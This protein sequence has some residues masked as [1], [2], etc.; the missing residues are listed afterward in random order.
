MPSLCIITLQIPYC[1]LRSE[2]LEART[3]IHVHGEWV[4]CSFSMPGVTSKLNSGGPHDATFIQKEWNALLPS[5]L[6][7]QCRV[8]PNTS[9]DWKEH[10]IPEEFFHGDTGIAE[11]PTFFQF[12]SIFIF[13]HHFPIFKSKCTELLMY[14]IWF[15]F[16]FCLPIQMSLC[17]IFPVYS[18]FMLQCKSVKRHEV[19]FNENM[20]MFSKL[21]VFFEPKLAKDWNTKVNYRMNK[22]YQANNIYNA[23]FQCSHLPL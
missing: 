7:M 11:A 16:H 6:L 23:L 14:K 19:L 13:L 1:S 18:T 5:L 22:Q 12:S 2:G 3:E 4:T 8:T 20:Q 17:H 9:N 21:F 15:L 10:Q